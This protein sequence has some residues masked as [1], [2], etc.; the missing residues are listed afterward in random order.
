MAATAEWSRD[1]VEAVDHDVIRAAIPRNPMTGSVAAS[2]VTV[3]LGTR[4]DP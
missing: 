3:A 1:A 2:Q 4:P